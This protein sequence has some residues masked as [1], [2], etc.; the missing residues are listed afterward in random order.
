MR[1]IVTTPHGTIEI[2]ARTHADLWDERARVLEVF[3]EDHCGL[4]GSVNL[5]PVTRMVDKIT[6]REMQ[7]RDC[8]AT[9][10]Y[11]STMEGGRLFPVRKLNSVGKPDRESGTWGAH[12]GWTKYRGMGDAYE[13][14]A[15][16]TVKDATANTATADP[17]LAL[18]EA[19]ATVEQLKAVCEFINVEITAKRLVNGRRAK[20]EAAIASRKRSLTAAA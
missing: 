3:T 6:F 2:E 1:A 9:L 5:I 15:T 17:Y 4:C 16:T 14:P 18:I 20:L 8:R 19:A 12:N 13:P 7:C 11:G 10:S